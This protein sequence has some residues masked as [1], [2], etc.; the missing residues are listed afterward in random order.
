MIEECGNKKNRFDSQGSTAIFIVHRKKL[1]ANKER[2][3]RKVTVFN[4]HT[5]Q[6]KLARYSHEPW[7]LAASSITS[8]NGFCDMTF[9]FLK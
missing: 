4:F 9:R 7:R 8:V 5:Q 2:C 1:V 6:S 3:M